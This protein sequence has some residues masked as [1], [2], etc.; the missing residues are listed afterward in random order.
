MQQI[1]GRRNAATW[2]VQES[3]L[4]TW[5]LTQRGEV[6]GKA[7]QAREPHEEQ[8]RKAS[9]KRKEQDSRVLKRSSGE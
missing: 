2:A 1:R 9:P 4:A 5:H 3:C 7:F 8:H 6:V